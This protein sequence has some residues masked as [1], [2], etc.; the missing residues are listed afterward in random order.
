[1]ALTPEVADHLRQAAVHL[2]IAGDAWQDNDQAA[3]DR[4]DHIGHALAMSIDEI[5]AEI[6]AFCD[7]ELP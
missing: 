6:M 1:M 3:F 7:G 4:S 2:M 5:A